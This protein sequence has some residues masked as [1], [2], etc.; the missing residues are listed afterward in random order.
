MLLIQPSPP[1]CTLFRVALEDLVQLEI[2]AEM[3]LLVPMEILVQLEGLELLE[4]LYVPI[5]T[6]ILNIV[7]LVHIS[8]VRNV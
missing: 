3:G 6:F 5:K 1:T 7:V 8:C 2:K 4:T